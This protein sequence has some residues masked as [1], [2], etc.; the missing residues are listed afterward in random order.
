MAIACRVAVVFGWGR[1]SGAGSVG[2][3]EA[4]RAL[5]GAEDGGLRAGLAMGGARMSSFEPSVVCLVA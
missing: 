5:M 4:G 2:R 1:R 3:R